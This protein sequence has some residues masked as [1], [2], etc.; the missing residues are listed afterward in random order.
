ML[1]QTYL[2]KEIKSGFIQ[3]NKTNRGK[4]MVNKFAPKIICNKCNKTF[5]NYNEDTER[6]KC[7]NCKEMITKI[8]HPLVGAV[9]GK[10]SNGHYTLNFPAFGEYNTYPRWED[11]RKELDRLAKN[12]VE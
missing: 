7:P 5:W 3:F 2:T 10:N 6:T 8:L 9:L 4:Q 12:E 11:L 1:I